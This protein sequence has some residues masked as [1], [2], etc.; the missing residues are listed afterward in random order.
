M[1]RLPAILFFYLIGA[2]VTANAL[3]LSDEEKG[4]LDTHK[5]LRLGVDATWPPFE[6]RDP[7]GRY[8]GLAAEYV[9]LIEK[10]LGVTL[11]PIEPASWNEVLNKAR[12]NEID[13]LP[14]VMSTPERQGYLAFTRPYLD[15]PIVILA[16]EGGA[17]PHNLRDLYG[18]RVG[19]VENYAPHELLRLQHPDLNLVTLP[20]VGSMLQALAAGRS[21]CCSG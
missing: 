12:R 21:R 1:S 13:L 17:H 18:L 10:R 11:K 2:T 15:F 14:G 4:W 6:F 19:V 9:A 3:T 5:E 8:Q 16:H 7:Q 20:N